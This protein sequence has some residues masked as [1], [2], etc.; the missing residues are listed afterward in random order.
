MITL[1]KTGG[2][3]AIEENKVI[4]FLNVTKSLEEHFKEDPHYIQEQ[5]KSFEPHLLGKLS[6]TYRDMITLNEDIRNLNQYS[7]NY[8][9]KS[10]K[11]VD[12]H[13]E[14]MGLLLMYK[15][16]CPSEENNSKEIID[17]YM[18]RD[19]LLKKN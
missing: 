5:F 14:F 1:H 17:D 2:F 4:K 18:K 9:K 13:S 11:L 12:L 10:K 7:E 16:I 6:R 8:K 15:K 19:W 3:N